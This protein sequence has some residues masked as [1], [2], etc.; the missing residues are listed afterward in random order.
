MK[1]SWLPRLRS[2]LLTAVVLC[3]G[4]GMPLLD[5]A[6]YHS[7]A[8][9]RSS[10]SHFESST[11]H[12]HGDSCRLGSALSHC[13]QVASLDLVLLTATASSPEPGAALS[14]PRSTPTGWAQARAPPSQTTASVLRLT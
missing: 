13:P 6:L 11:P 4:G 12:S 1:V 7:L 9:E 8:P 3:G 14:A 10:V 2:S 5:L